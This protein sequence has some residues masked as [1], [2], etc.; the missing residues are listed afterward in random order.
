MRNNHLD[1][2]GEQN[3]IDYYTYGGF[4]VSC[5]DLYNGHKFLTHRFNIEDNNPDEIIYKFIIENKL[6]FEKIIKYAMD[7]KSRTVINK[8]LVLAR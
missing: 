7:T 5:G 6:D 4:L 8:I 1:S 3:E 2:E